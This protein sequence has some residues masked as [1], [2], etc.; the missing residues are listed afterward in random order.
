M[1]SVTIS[2]ISYVNKE[3]S[4][5]YD[6]FYQETN[7]INDDATIVHFTKNTQLLKLTNIMQENGEQV[8]FGETRF[9]AQKMQMQ[10]FYERMNKRFG[11]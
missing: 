9:D 6:A 8:Y 1:S 11:G 10:D 3:D 2:K 5:H 4:C 7:Y